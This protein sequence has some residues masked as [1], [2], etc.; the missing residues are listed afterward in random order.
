MEK[1]RYLISR[2]GML[3]PFVLTVISLIIKN[4]TQ[5]PHSQR[6]EI[7]MWVFFSMFVVWLVSWLVR[8]G[9]G[10]W[11]TKKEFDKLS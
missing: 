6:A 5:E 9:I 3:I 4:S 1:F 11:K 8:V 2:F 10:W 7:A